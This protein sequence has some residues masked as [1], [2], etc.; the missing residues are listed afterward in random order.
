M[1]LN[2]LVNFYLVYRVL[3]ESCKNPIFL[4][5]VLTVDSE[6]LPCY[7]STPEPAV[8]NNWCKGVHNGPKSCCSTDTLQE[9]RNFINSVEA[10]LNKELFEYF[11]GVQT[12]FL[13]FSQNLK[14]FD[15]VGEE[16][17]EV[18]LRNRPGIKKLSQ[19]ERNMIDKVVEQVNNVVK[20]ISRAGKQCIQGQVY[21]LIG[22]LCIGC[23]PYWTDYI[24]EEGDLI[25]ITILK[26]VCENLVSDCSQ[27]V[28]IINRFPEII[29]ESANDIKKI[30]INAVMHNP[31]LD[32]NMFGIEDLDIIINSQV[33]GC[34]IK[35]DCRD[36]I[37]EHLAGLNGEFT[38]SHMKFEKKGIDTY[39]IGKASKNDYPAN[40]EQDLAL[41]LGFGSI[42][43]YL[44]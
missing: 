38:T 2:I 20:A 10:K 6:I 13:E 25:S 15:S 41:F 4:P 32:T 43:L 11:H 21:H 42:S 9:I 8:Y 14:N 37:C 26:A 34:S 35:A 30:I 29:Q 23:D 18:R 22:K 33:I 17:I 31:E 16:L 19:Y 24:K 40:N 27:Y 28:D 7:L 12:T 39:N 1:G 3:G 36:L 44:L 5:A